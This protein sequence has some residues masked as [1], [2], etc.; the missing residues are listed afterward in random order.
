M[1]AM[2]AFR[3]IVNEKKESSGGVIKFSDDLRVC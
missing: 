2:I 3:C 1:V